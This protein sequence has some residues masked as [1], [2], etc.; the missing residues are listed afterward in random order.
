MFW[1]NFNADYY[2]SLYFR[3]S[4]ALPENIRIFAVSIDK[5]FSTGATTPLRTAPKCFA[6]IVLLPFGIW[7]NC[8]HMAELLL[9]SYFESIT[10]RSGIFGATFDSTSLQCRS[11][12]TLNFI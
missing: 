2:K 1:F 6:A 10:T 11:T 3:K 12:A 4:N 7:Q 8:C 9:R 5:G